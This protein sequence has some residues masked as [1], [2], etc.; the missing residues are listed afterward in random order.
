MFNIIQFLRNLFNGKNER[1][2]NIEQDNNIPQII[3]PAVGKKRA[4]CFGINDYPGSSNDLRGCLNDVAEWSK[5]L[6]FAYKFDEVATMTDAN[7]TKDNIVKAMK[8]IIEKSVANDVLVLQYSGHGTYTK[9][10][11][12]DEI[13]GK[14]EAICLYNGLLIDDEINE[15]MSKVKDGVRCSVIFDSCFSGTS[16]RAFNM[17]N[18][19]IY[20]VARFMPPKDEGKMIGLKIN[21]AFKAVGQTEEDMNH[22]LISGCSYSEYSYDAFYDSTY[23][24]ALSYNA[25]NNVLKEDPFITYLEFYNRLKSY[26]PSREYPQNPQ[27][28]GKSEFKNRI[29]FS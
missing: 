14:D 15:I 24:G 28:E 13:D 8:E 19:A 10:L 25:I 5:L 6:K 23:H 11:N 4:L 2:E 16:T 26:L 18:D 29:M 7:C 3:V 12:K 1:E 22:V 27:L 20:R 21:R 17:D 9:D